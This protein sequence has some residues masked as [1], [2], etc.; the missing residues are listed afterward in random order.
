M[1]VPDFYEGNLEPSFVR[2][3]LAGVRV[4]G[5]KASEGY[6]YVDHRVAGRAARARRLR[7]RRIFY[8]FARPDLHPEGAHAEADHFL[9]VAAPL[10][11]K[12]DYLALDL[13][14]GDPSPA[15]IAWCRSFNHRVHD[16]IGRWPLFYANRDYCNRLRA[17]SPIGGGLWLADYG[18]NDG[19]RHPGPPPA[20]WKHVKL[21]QYTSR[22]SVRGATP[23]TDLSFAANL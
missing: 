4:V 2:L 18:P 15:L 16:R 7:I 21:H 6:T 17:Q 13:E 5:L 19:R 3:R 8:H 10:L 12:G 14:R 9:A 1:V 23:P 20:P 11:R 22:G